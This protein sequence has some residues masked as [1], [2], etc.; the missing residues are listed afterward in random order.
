MISMKVCASAPRRPWII[1]C[2]SLLE[3]I[4]SIREGSS[5]GE[6]AR[7]IK[8][9]QAGAEET[10]G[11]VFRTR[12]SKPWLRRTVLGYRGRGGVVRINK[13]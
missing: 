5:S 2:S 10:K 7:P 8:R 12:S 9:L 6:N 3:K 11:S 4:A 13:R 1:S